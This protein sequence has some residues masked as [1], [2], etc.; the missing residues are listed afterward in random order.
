MYARSGLQTST[1]G[2]LEFTVD[3]SG[4]VAGVWTGTSPINSTANIL[5]SVDCVTG[6]FTANLENGSYSGGTFPF[7]L[8]GTFTGQLTGA[9]EPTTGSFSD[10]TWAVTEPNGTSGGSGTWTA[11]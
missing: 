5:G 6:T 2:T 3:A 8:S 10:G 9:F 7:Q 11:D 1:Q 4:V